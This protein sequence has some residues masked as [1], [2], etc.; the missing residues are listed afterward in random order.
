MRHLLPAA[1]AAV[2]TLG[3]GED[4]VLTSMR[5][6]PGNPT[7]W[8]DETITLKVMFFDQ[9]GGSL[10]APVGGVEW[11]TSKP[12][13]LGEVK[14]GLVSPLMHGDGIVTVSAAGGEGKTIEA[15]TA[16]T[17]KQIH[18]LEAVAYI[19]QVNQ[20]PREP[21]RL[22]AGRPGMFRAHAV[23]DSQPGLIA[24][25]ARVRLWNGGRTI[26]DTILEQ[27]DPLVL[28]EVDQSSFDYSYN[29]EVEGADVSEGLMAS[30]VFD[31]NDDERSIEGGDT[32]AFDVADLDV[33]NQ[34]LVP[35][36]ESAYP[37]RAVEQWVTDNA[38]RGNMGNKTLTI[39]PIGE[40]NLEAHAPYETDLNWTEDTGGSWTGLLRELDALRREEQKLDYYYYGAIRPSQSGNVL[41]IA[42]G[43]GHPV[44]CGVDQTETYMHETGHSMNLRHAPCGGAGGPDPNYPNDNGYLDWW[45]F[46]P[47]TGRLLTPRA[48][49]DLMGYCGA[50]WISA[51]HFKRGVDFRAGRG[52][53]R[54]GGG[55]AERVLGVTGSV[56]DGV[57]TV[58]PVFEA[59]APPETGNGGPYLIEGHDPGG[60]ALFS[61]RFT[62]HSPLDIEAG[63]IFSLAIPVPAGLESITVSGPEGAASVT[64]YS[65][66]PTAMLIDE[67]GEV[68]AIRRNWDGSNP[69]RWTVK[70]STGLPG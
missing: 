8:E 57:L 20:H 16:I 66:P 24:P 30:V 60:R 11:T 19:T 42:Y 50:T 54:R 6:E 18:E 52:A 62:P 35:V 59:V 36:I 65:H 14:D 27:A 21:I 37:N 69:N 45:G 33:Q 29:L 44:S 17:V 53:H 12:A 4:P 58:D 13:V 48:Y 23:A 5:I 40:Q 9:N 32:I 39:L 31:P 1:L 26:V 22:V 63:R 70:V 49:T 2:M 67:N 68:R 28:Q 56:Y 25:D 51:Y 64:R 38:N 43:F 10:E 55:P 61:H 46:D 47:N 41:G 7:I 15:S 34:M 3:C